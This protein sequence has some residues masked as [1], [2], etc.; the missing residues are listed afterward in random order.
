M[1]REAVDGGLRRIV[2]A[3]AGLAAAVIVGIDPLQFPQ[4]RGASY[5]E[6]EEGAPVMWK[7]RPQVGVSK[8]LGG[9]RTVE[10]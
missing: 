5:V 8:P 6:G 3:V 4:R 2:V 9:D 1:M 7:P 10:V